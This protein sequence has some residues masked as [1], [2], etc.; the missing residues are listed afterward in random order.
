MVFTALRRIGRGALSKLSHF[1]YIV[2]WLGWDFSLV[3]VNLFTF[4][5]KVGRVTPRGHPGEGGIWPEYIPPQEG[6]S[7]CSCPGLNTMANHGARQSFIS[8]PTFH[9]LPF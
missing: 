1:F 6:D 7:R 2:G 8:T 9:F 3:L 4:K 5:R